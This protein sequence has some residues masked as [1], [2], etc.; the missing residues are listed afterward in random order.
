VRRPILIDLILHPDDRIE[1][2]YY[3]LKKD[4]DLLIIETDVPQVKGQKAFLWAK[5]SPLYDSRGNIVGAIESIRDITDRKL[6][7]ESV[8]KRG[9]EL[10]IKTHID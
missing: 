9:K 10:K 3:V 8:R 4:R 6:V 2:G 5:A 1:R 7:E